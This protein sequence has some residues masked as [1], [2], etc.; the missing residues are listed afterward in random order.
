MV[1]Q[2]RGSRSRMTMMSSSRRV[3]CYVELQRISRS[4]LGAAKTTRSYN[5][6]P[7]SY[8]GSLGALITFSAPDDNDHFHIMINMKHIINQLRQIQCGIG[9]K[10]PSEEVPEVFSDVLLLRAKNLL[11]VLQEDKIVNKI[12]IIFNNG[13]DDDDGDDENDNVDSD[14]DK[15]K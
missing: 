3:N 4:L 9:R 6:L 10:G 12:Q 11:Q 1:M 8:D 2:V 5:E 7:R 14:S 13:N 15:S